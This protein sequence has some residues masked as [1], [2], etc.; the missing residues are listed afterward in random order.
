M[1]G[2]SVRGDA[3]LPAVGSSGR[4]DTE[5]HFNRRFY[6]PLWADARL[7]EPERFNTWPLVQ[8]LLPHAPRRLEVAPG[9]RP[10]LPIPGTQFVDISASALSKLRSRGGSVAL[11]SVTSLPFA[12]GAF[13]LVCSLD[14]IEHVEDDERALAELSRVCAHGAVLLLSAPLHPGRWTAFDELVGHRRRY[15]PATLFAKLAQ[16]NLI[17]VRSAVFGMRPRSSKLTDF[18]MWS[19]AH[20]RSRAMWWYN[21]LVMPLAVRFARKLVVCDGI[22]DPR[23]VDELLLICRKEAGAA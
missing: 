22:V 16:R 2:K 12:D 13:E 3:A 19:L 11:G 1:I 21:H 17:A 5:L 6:D 14:I 9:L 4:D 20:R 15:E 23:N 18:G 8:A 7:V 10:R